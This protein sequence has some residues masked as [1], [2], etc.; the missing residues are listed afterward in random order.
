MAVHVTQVHNADIIDKVVIGMVF[1]L[2]QG[3]MK[4]LINGV[5]EFNNMKILL[6]IGASRITR[7]DNIDVR[8]SDLSEDRW[9]L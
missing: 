7:P 5:I 2:G 9:R 6:N 4:N 1:L 3:M 8:S